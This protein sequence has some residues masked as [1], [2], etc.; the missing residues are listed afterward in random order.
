MKKTKILLSE[1]FHIPS[2][3]RRERQNQYPKHTYIHDRS[4]SCLGAGTSITSG[5]DKLVLC[6]VFEMK[7]W[8]Y[9]SESNSWFKKKN[10]STWKLKKI[11]LLVWE[12][13]MG[14]HREN[15]LYSPN[16]TLSNFT[17]KQICILILLCNIDFLINIYRPNCFN[18]LLSMYSP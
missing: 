1:Q 16:S 17:F 2:K 9:R 3:I 10:S 13:R 4:L 15:E 6:T 18:M 5:G 12:Q 8:I 11:V 7:S 14:G